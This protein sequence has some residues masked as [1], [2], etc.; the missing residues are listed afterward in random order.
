MQDLRRVQAL[1]GHALLPEAEVPE[2]A[3]QILRAKYKFPVL[4][5]KLV[6]ILVNFSN[7]LQ[8]PMEEVC[9]K[10]STVQLL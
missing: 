6:K 8:I 4:T 9:G 3:G 7:L 5:I 2:D 1:G 10:P